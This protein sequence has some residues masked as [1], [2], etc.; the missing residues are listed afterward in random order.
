M[1]LRHSPYGPGWHYVEYELRARGGSRVVKKLR[2]YGSAR[3]RDRWPVLV[4]VRDE[5]VERTFQEVGGRGRS[6][7]SRRRWIGSR[8]LAFLGPSA[9][10]MY[11]ESVSAWLSCASPVVLVVR[12]DPVGASRNFAIKSLALVSGSFCN[13]SSTSYHKP[14]KGSLRVRQ[15]R[16]GRT[17]AL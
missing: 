1:L 17:R 12:G 14:S 2:G 8:A 6:V 16:G 13:H 7:C 3:R 4:V 15:C 11:G 9:G 10:P 5:G